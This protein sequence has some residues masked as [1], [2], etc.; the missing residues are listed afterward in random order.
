MGSDAPEVYA[1]KV[2]PGTL[3]VMHNVYGPDD[4]IEQ[5]GWHQQII[6]AVAEASGHRQFVIMH[7]YGDPT[8]RVQHWTLDE[9]LATLAG[10]T[11]EGTPDA[12]S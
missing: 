7:T 1:I 9:V 2:E 5:Q 11:Q 8:V 6:A 12:E 3:L 4:E 10:T